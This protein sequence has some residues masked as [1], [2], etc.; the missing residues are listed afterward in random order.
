MGKEI[1]PQDRDLQVLY[2]FGGPVERSFYIA[3]LNSDHGVLSP[4]E[5]QEPD[6][7]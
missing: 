2:N 6:R 5:K 1:T 4:Q 3:P 7:P